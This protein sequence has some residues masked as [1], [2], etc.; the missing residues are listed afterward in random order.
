MATKAIGENC[1]VQ[2]LVE[3]NDERN[4]FKAFIDHLKLPGRIDSTFGCNRL[5][6]IVEQVLGFVL[7]VV[8][9]GSRLRTGCGSQGARS[10]RRRKSM[11][12]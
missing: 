7:A 5:A 3:G 6:E 4:F 10:L 12:Q 8:R 1:E 11:R 9:S 2:L